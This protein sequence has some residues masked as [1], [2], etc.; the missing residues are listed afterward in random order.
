[1]LCYKKINYYNFD[2]EN[3]FDFDGSDIL[4]DNLSLKNIKSK[5]VKRTK[6]INSINDKTDKAK[7][8]S[9]ENTIKQNTI[10][11]SDSSLKPFQTF[12]SKIN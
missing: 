1:M 3:S 11:I 7:F 9:N 4:S 10:F 5:T 12:C 6:K 8:S 2:E